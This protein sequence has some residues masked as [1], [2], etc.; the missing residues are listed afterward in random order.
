ME[1]L[2]LVSAKFQGPRGSTQ[3]SQTSAS[4]SSSKHYPSGQLP[5]PS[6]NNGGARFSCYRVWARRVVPIRGIRVC[7]PACVRRGVEERFGVSQ[8]G[9]QVGPNTCTCESCELLREGNDRKRPRSDSESSSS[10]GR[11]ETP[12]PY[13]DTGNSRGQASDAESGS[14]SDA[15]TSAPPPNGAAPSSPAI[16]AR[17][18][19]ATGRVLVVKTIG[20]FHLDGITDHLFEEGTL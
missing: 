7:P 19:V 1:K 3:T 4:S 2:P 13:G 14:E 17:G 18:S 15:S 12:P 8:T 5:P 6:A 9:F 16:Q 20:R 11:S 10:S